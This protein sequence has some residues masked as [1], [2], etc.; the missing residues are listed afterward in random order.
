MVPVK[1]ILRNFLSY[2]EEPTILDFTGFRVAC[3]SGENGHGKS[4]ILDAMTYAL[5]GEA[6]KGRSDRK[7]DDGLLRLGASEMEVELT[8][9]L[10]AGRYRAIR[11]YRRRPRSS[12]TELDLQV[13]DEGGGRYRSLSAGHVTKT[14][15]RIVSLLSMDYDTFINS[16]FLLQGRSD[17]FTRKG[18]GERKRIL[19]E[20][21]GLGRY[22]RLEQLARTQL[23]ENT[24]AR[25][26]TERLLESHRLELSRQ[27]SYENHLAQLEAERQAIEVELANRESLL[28]TC[29]AA[30]SET[31]EQRAR[32]GRAREE[33]GADDGRLR[34]LTESRKQLRERRQEDESA[35]AAG[36][37]IEAEFERFGQL[38]SE[39][40]GLAEK[41]TLHRQLEESRSV[42][43]GEI[44]EQRHELE[45]LL[46]GLHSEK[47]TVELALAESKSFLSRT[48]V[49]ESEFAQ[50]GEAR[51][52]ELALE[53]ER[54]QFELLRAR[55]GE[56]QHEIELEKNRLETELSALDEQ[57]ASL[58][59]QLQEKG[60]L[61]ARS[62]QKSSELSHAEMLAKELER[63]KTEGANAKAIRGQKEVKLVELEQAETSLR[64][65]R[66]ALETT[67]NAECPLCGSELDEAHL[68]QLLEQL[69]REETHHRQLIQDE[70]DWLREA[71]A[72]VSALRERYRNLESNSDGATALR[73]E[74]AHLG[75]RL[76][77]LAE[78]ETSL[79][80]ID[81]R[82]GELSETLRALDY[83]QTQ[84]D[85]LRTIEEEL[86]D[87]DFNPDELE[88]IRDRIRQLARAATEHELLSQAREKVDAVGAKVVAIDRIVEADRHR[89]ETGEY[90]ADKREA[91][92]AVSAQLRTLAY[93]RQ[94][95]GH[96]VTKL[97]E[98]AGVPTEHAHLTAAKQRFDDDSRT[99][100]LLDREIAEVETK[101]S[102]LS[103]EAESLEQCLNAATVTEAELTRLR[104]DLAEQRGSRDHALERRGA[105]QAKLDRCRQ[106]KGEV[107]LLE[108]QLESD[109]REAVI[110]GHL[111]EAFGKDGIQALL[112]EATIPEIE[113]E[114][115]SI[116]R[117]LTDN[118]IQIAIES[119][120][121]LKGG[122]TRETL[123]IRIADEIGERSYHLFSG[124]EAFR[125]DFALRIALSKVL[126]R[127][128]GTRLRTLIIDEG[129][130][131][132]DGRGLE[133]LK[134]AIQEISSDFDKLIVVTH[135]PELK[136]AFPVQIEVSKRPEVGSRV[137]VLG[138]S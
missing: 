7:P 105:L 115:N 37:R 20:I 134:E 116:L 62:G 44:V 80:D 93:D 52:R 111:E 109:C 102:R 73:R 135:L 63:L 70:R 67:S 36:A 100:A 47:Q 121:D 91:L 66:Q 56:T 86:A 21:L 61:E 12:V 28:A 15:R 79:Q 8:F 45:Q 1:L 122:G 130:G 64:E 54:S 55:R 72:N 123:D 71:G 33:L 84:R 46:S 97:D 35:L 43:E 27:A 57:C 77:R 16:A 51:S 76:A 110:Y 119:L 87:L 74:V 131:T 69:E 95:H 26:T 127:R 136:E 31:V 128:S 39:G 65:K 2:G 19:A 40:R 81:R 118:R 113:K 125:A 83:C 75:A 124:G 78:D 9:D 59:T 41:E 106:V 48:T 82:R 88:R 53:A 133:Y 114:A 6:R 34:D 58:E 49:I 32:L 10:D 137:E 11:R 18:A 42:I 29:Q 38:T 101:R 14:Q 99:I 92:A 50:L 132:Q 60:A 23:K 5:W 94:R 138:L 126:A 108:K 120:R 17:E 25:E 85:H 98:L 90:A 112:I 24:L 4:A 22:E 89:L 129:F 104:N 3:L 103:D 68:R 13:Y 30:W 96:V 117:R 107:A